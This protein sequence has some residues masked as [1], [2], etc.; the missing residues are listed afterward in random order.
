MGKIESQ[1]LRLGVS[2]CLLGDRVRWDGGHKRDAFLVEILGPDVEWVPVCPE[3]ELG[4]GVPRDPIRLVHAGAG[5]PPRLVVERTGEDLTAR[6]RRFARERAGALAR[7]ALDGYVLKRGSPS[8]GP[9]DVPVHDADGRTIATAAGAFAAVLTTHLPAL[10]VEDEDRLADP[11]IRERFLARVAA[12]HR[13]RLGQP[14]KHD[15]K[16]AEP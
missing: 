14:L 9:A 10:P 7:L 5:V 2:A 3:V 13:A 4:L 1:R 11:A 8:C 15:A 6:M 16:N 12:A